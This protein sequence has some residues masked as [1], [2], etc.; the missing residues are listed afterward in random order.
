MKQIEV[1]VDSIYKNTKGNHEEIQELKAE[2]KNHLLEAVHE[3]KAEGKTEK[4]AIE[5]AIDRFGGEKELRSIIGQLFKTQQTFARWVLYLAF[6]FL[7]LFLS[8]FGW[9][10]QREETQSNQIS[11]VATDI[12]GILENKSSITPEMKADI[13]DS[14]NSTNFISAVR[15]FNV[16]DIQ[17][18]DNYGGYGNVFQYVEQAEPDYHYERTV[19]APEWLSPAF[20]PYGNGDDQ[21]YV[22]MEERSFGTIMSIV[23]FVGVAV[24]WTLFGIWAIINAY[25]HKR[26]N[27]FWGLGFIL[28][29]VAGYLVYYIVGRKQSYSK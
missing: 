24:Y 3:L 27:M 22:G 11:H 16:N 19:W 8:V 6:G 25:H 2:M 4:E 7:V 18:T 20:Y 28:F 15:I 1:F 10:W 17:R 9:L 26:L 29:N 12:A 14:I 23:L 5:L 13:E 21:W